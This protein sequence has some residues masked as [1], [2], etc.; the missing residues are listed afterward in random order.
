MSQPGIAGMLLIPGGGGKTTLKSNFP[1]ALCDIDDFWDPSGH[2]ELAMTERYR[3]AINSG[4]L[5][6]ADGIVEECTLLKALRCRSHCRKG[7]YLMLAQ[8][9]AQADIL[10]G[11]QTATSDNVIRA[12][13]SASLHEEKLASRGDSKRVADLCRRQ[14]CAIIDSATCSE[15]ITVYATH[16]QLEEQLQKFLEHSGLAFS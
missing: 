8:T 14:R 5:T 1:A 10:L 4:D 3:L 2:E 11:R 9:P 12:V 13:P 16:K 15:T 6:A 7:R